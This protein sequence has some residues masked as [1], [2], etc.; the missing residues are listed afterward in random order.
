MKR[1]DGCSPPC[2]KNRKYKACSKPFQKDEV[3]NVQKRCANMILE[4]I[5]ASTDNDMN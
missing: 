2:V 5:E 1:K 3:K 4:Y